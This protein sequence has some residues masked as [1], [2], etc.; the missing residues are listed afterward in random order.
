LDLDIQGRSQRRQRQKLEDYSQEPRRAQGC[1][2]MPEARRDNGFSPESLARE[3]C[4]LVK[5]F[6]T[7]RIR[8]EYVSVVL[9]LSVCGAQLRQ[10]W[11]G[12][13]PLSASG[14]CLTVRRE[15]LTKTAWWGFCELI[16]KSMG[17]SASDNG[18]DSRMCKYCNS[19]VR[20]LTAPCYFLC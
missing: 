14:C 3:C 2:Q 20:R 6:L 9:S 10:P 8:Q 1:W 12:H 15:G 16:H 18:V 13:S 11:V 19:S 4:H 7:S 17:W 5:G